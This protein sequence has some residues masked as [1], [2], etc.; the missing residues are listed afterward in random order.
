MII[1]YMESHFEQLWS[2]YQSTEFLL[3][4]PLSSVSRFAI[5]TAHNPQG[6]LLSPCQNRLLD[7][8]LLADIE[9]MGVPYRALIGTNSTLS[10]MEKSWAVF[11]SEEESLELALKYR[12]NAIYYVVQD[13][14]LL[15]PCLMEREVVSL[16]SFRARVKLVQELPELDL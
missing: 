3:T 14:L 10:H 12:Q 4:Q 9:A 2:C 11:A 7:R 5:V 13:E 16:G 6:E 15:L 8:K 1:T